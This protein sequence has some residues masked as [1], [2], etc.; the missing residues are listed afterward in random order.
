MNIAIIGGG[1]IGLTTAYALIRRGHQVDLI[2]QNENIGLG[3]SFANGGQ[4]S[5]RYASPLADEGVPLQALKW[6]FQRHSPLHFK[7]LLSLKQWRWC[8]HFLAACRRSVNLHNTEHLL[9]LALYSQQ[10]LKDWREQDQLGDFG[11]RANGKLT[12][13]RHSNSWKKAS[14]VESC[15]QRQVL[16]PDQCIKI[17]PALSHLSSQILGGIYAPGDEVADC[18]LFCHRLLE[19]LQQSPSFRVHTG[20]EVTKLNVKNNAISHLTLKSGDLK[21]DHLVMAAGIGSATLLDRIGIKVPLYPL[22]GYSLSLDLP[23]HHNVPETNLTDYDRKVVFARINQ[24]LRIAAMVDIGGWNTH[25]SADRIASLRHIAHSSF[26][27]AGDFNQAR[28]WMGMRPATPNGVPVLG[29]SHLKNLWL[30]IG[31]GSLGFTLACGSAEVL[32]HLLED[33]LPAIPL[34]GFSST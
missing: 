4:L 31:H 2:E 21:T 18:F 24:E 11:W 32:S 22:K 26:P 13:Y 27:Q 12:I 16:T 28:T 25:I 34:T 10:I 23:S 33:R 9:R 1:V 7:P 8:L 30:N 19:R 20:Q 3:T 6:M 15:S 29:A 5:Y 17:E 14:Q